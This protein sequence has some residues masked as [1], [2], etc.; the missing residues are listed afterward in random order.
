MAPSLKGQVSAIHAVSVERKSWPRISNPPGNSFN[1]LEN[2][3]LS[4][5][6]LRDQRS[7]GTTHIFILYPCWWHPLKGQ[8]S[9]IHTVSVEGKSCSRISNPAQNSFNLLEMS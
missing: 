6:P 1:L 7:S 3:D 9:P 5:N 2:E 8:V 4:I